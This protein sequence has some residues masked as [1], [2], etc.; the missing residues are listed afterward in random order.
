MAAAHLWQKRLSHDDLL[1]PPYSLDP[2]SNHIRNGLYAVGTLAFLSVLST[3]ALL[4]WVTYGMFARPKRGQMNV[5]YNQYILLIYQLLLADL[6]Q[7]LG[8]VFSIHWI[9][10]NKIVG[11]SAACFT[12]GWFIHIGDVSSGF[13]VLAIAFHTWISV[14]K[15]RKLPHGLFVAI[16]LGIWC[17]AAFLTML[18]PLINGR[19]VFLRAGSWVGLFTAHQKLCWIC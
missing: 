14:V 4:V 3:S 1:S 19:Y 6:Q 7:S 8:F 16:I 10:Q 11:P 13:F 2:L 9:S 15:G 18:A 12:Q 17:L 5:G